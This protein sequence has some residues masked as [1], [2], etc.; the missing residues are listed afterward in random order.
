MP[1]SE[2]KYLM[3]FNP[4]SHT[5]VFLSYDEPNK[6]S[7]YQHLLSLNPNAL[8]VDG[9]KGSDN[10]HK[11]VAF[12][13]FT[14]NVIV[15]DADNIVKPD[16]F[17]T[18]FELPESYNPKTNV[19]S[20]SAYNTING[21]SY[22]NGGIK[23][24]PVSLLESM[25]THENGTGVDFDLSLYTELDMVA[26]EVQF[27]SNYQAWRAGFREGVKLL[28][29]NDKPKTLDEIDYR[30]FDRLWMWTHVGA[31]IPHGLYAIHGARLAVSWMLSGNFNYN[32]IIDFDTIDDFF[33]GTID[34]SNRLGALIRNHTDNWLFGDVLDEV[35]SARFRLWNMPPKRK[36]HN[37]DNEFEAWAFNFRKAVKT[38]NENELNKLCTMG[39]DQQFGNYLIDGAKHGKEHRETYKHDYKKLGLMYDY[40]WLKGS[41]DR[42]YADSI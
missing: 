20:F 31:D 1:K 7:N 18:S 32:Q 27:T 9:I 26:S 42:L 33:S 30:N 4:L 5:T 38:N 23:V 35:D 24:W 8:R 6:E 2:F 28:L 25:Q 41:Y 10:A 22:G 13:S 15:V 40:S 17:T 16:F 34:D 3:L 37:I 36:G 11:A 19:L 39:R 21:N 14:E 29:E 12:A